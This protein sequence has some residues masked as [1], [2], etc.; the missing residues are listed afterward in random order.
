ME[1]LTFEGDGSFTYQPDSGFTGNDTF[2]YTASDGTNTS[3]ETTVT[4][5]VQDDSTNTAPVATAESYAV[6]EDQVLTVGRSRWRAQ[7]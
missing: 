5:T 3:S 6:D 1:T 2:T 4:I 7:Q